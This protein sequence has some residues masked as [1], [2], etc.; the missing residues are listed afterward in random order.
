[1]LSVTALHCTVP[2][3]SMRNAAGLGIVP[4]SKS[5]SYRRIVSRVASDRNVKP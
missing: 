2:V 3:A 1:M 5:T 4:D